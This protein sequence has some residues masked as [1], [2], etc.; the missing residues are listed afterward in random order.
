[1][2]AGKTMI[3]VPAEFADNE[4]LDAEW[5]NTAREDN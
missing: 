1:V 4:E 2:D 5:C 3:I